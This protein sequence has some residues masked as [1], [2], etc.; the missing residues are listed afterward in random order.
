M[1]GQPSMSTSVDA[2]GCSA[3]HEGQ[4]RAVHGEV[5]GRAGQVI[6]DHLEHGQQ[7]NEGGSRR[8]GGRAVVYLCVLAQLV[9]GEFAVC[10]AVFPHYLPD[11]H[12]AHVEPRVVDA[13][14]VVA[15][16]LAAGKKTA[17]VNG[18]AHPASELE[19]R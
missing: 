17:A 10:R 1:R 14:L 19:A 18:N 6:P 3:K 12:A 8:A 15:D 7:R 4:G 2:S 11:L 13:P 5:H 16:A 9:E